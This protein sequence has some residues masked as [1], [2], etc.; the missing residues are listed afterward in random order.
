LPPSRL[1]AAMA[2]VSAPLVALSIVSAAVESL[3]PLK[4][5]TATAPPAGAVVLSEATNWMRM[6]H[7]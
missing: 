5:I 3:P 6:D 7:S 1:E 2:R 4:A